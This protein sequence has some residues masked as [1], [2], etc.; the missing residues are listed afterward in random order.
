ML[1]TAPERLTR[2]LSPARN[3]ALERGEGQKEKK[4]QK[5]LA[6]VDSSAL[7]GEAPSP[8]CRQVTSPSFPASPSG[9]K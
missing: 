4:E 3:N 7:K 6:E 2:W 8:P 1:A 5:E 9:G